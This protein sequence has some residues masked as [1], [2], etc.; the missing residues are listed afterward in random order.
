MRGDRL[1]ALRERHGHTQES[2]AE[3]LGRDIKQV[4]RWET[5]KV[6]PS[7][8]AVVQLAKTFNVSADYL[9]GLTDAPNAVRDTKL[10]RQEQFVISRYRGLTDKERVLIVGLMDMMLHEGIDAL[11]KAARASLLDDTEDSE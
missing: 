1:K 3:L 2:L 8:D 11:E 4:W 7:S 9:L 5:E 6:T 10:N